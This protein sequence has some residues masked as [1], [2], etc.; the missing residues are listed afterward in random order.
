VTVQ[1]GSVR[2]EYGNANSGSLTLHP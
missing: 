1:P 2:D